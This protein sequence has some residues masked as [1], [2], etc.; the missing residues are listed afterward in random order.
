[1]SLYSSSRGLAFL[2]WFFLHGNWKATSNWS[3]SQQFSWVIQWNAWTCE[4]G[5][6]Q[7]LVTSKL[8]VCSGSKSRF[9]S[10]SLKWVGVSSKLSLG[11]GVKMGC[12][13]YKRE[14]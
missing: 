5:I 14:S 4:L 6:N 7:D 8:S 3:I 2:G 10:Y 13:P 11:M 9:T 1:M 12:D